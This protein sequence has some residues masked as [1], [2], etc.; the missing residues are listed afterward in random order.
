M[1]LSRS[2]RAL[3]NTICELALEIVT[4]ICGFILPR[5]I[6]SHFGSTY[7]GIIA[8]ITQFI[9]CITLLKSGIGSVTRAALYKPLA[10]KNPIE[11]SAVVNATSS[12]MSKIVRIFGIFII[13]FAAT[14][15]FVVQDNFDWLFTFLLILILSISTFAQYYFG[16]TYQMVLQADQKNYII[17]LVTITSTII[18]TIV[19][20]IL[21]ELG[22]DIHIVKL[23]SA[24]VFT[25][26]PVF[27]NIW[28]RKHYKISKKVKANSSLISQRWDAFGHQVA[29]FINTNTD[30][31]VATVFLGVLEVS[32]YSVYMLIGNAIKKA[33]AAL[34]SGTMAAF[35]NMLVKKEDMTLKKRFTQFE[36]LVFF[37]STILLV[38]A[39]ILI[40]PFV[41]LY[42]K[43]IEDVN[44][45]RTLFG[46]LV[47]ISI[48]LMCIKIPYEQIVFAAGQFKKT[49]RGAYIEAI[50]NI[51]LSLILV[52]VLGLNGIIIGTI[53]ATTYRIITYYKYI[54]NNILEKS[55]A[56][57]LQNTIAA[58]I[59]A[60]LSWFVVKQFISIAIESYRAWIIYAIIVLLIVATITII[61][62]L[63]LCKK[64]TLETA[65]A[66]FHSI[67]KPG[68]RRNK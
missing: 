19:A 6:L 47:C 5:L 60:L 28:V 27:Y 57:I 36:T 56:N 52:N 59:S 29:N 49:K 43:G 39:S 8:S 12:F 15:P 13:I 25:I 1:S 64:K 32:V 10:D 63:L 37:A 65:K 46:I 42:T 21:I 38:T 14:F 45:A 20:A 33:I 30:I 16:L 18:N 26:P 3:I 22:F 58:T 41:S 24:I 35:G 17:S 67:I 54:R 9:G 2:N 44:Y 55:I 68:K 48:F 31:I 62:N 53:I 50:T 11:I 40:T 23:G 34:G 4:A 51:S 61:I 66:T 7:N